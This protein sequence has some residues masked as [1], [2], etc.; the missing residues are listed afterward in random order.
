MIGFDAMILL[1][2]VGLLDCAATEALRRGLKALAYKVV[3][4]VSMMLH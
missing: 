4:E 2:V 1:P 3:A